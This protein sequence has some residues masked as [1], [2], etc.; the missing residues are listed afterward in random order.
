MR[1]AFSLVLLTMIA[2]AGKKDHAAAPAPAD[3]TAKCESACSADGAKL[4][5]T[6]D[7]QCVCA[8]PE[9]PATTEARFAC[10]SAGCAQ[11]CAPGSCANWVQHPNGN[12]T[13]YCVRNWTT[14]RDVK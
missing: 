4:E 13:F 6:R 7:G 1:L 10:T 14:I 9:I 11:A 8:L 2:C 3:L 12:C 5:S